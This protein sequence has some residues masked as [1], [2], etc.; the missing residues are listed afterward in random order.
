G[1]ATSISPLKL[2]VGSVV[3]PVATAS[4]HVKSV[5]LVGSYRECA[6]H[7][8]GTGWQMTLGPGNTT[9]KVAQFD[10]TCELRA[11]GLRRQLWN[12]VAAAVAGQPAPIE[13]SEQYQFHSIATDE[14]GT[15]RG[16]PLAP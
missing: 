10:S 11:T 16:G 6:G 1:A 12:G 2:D 9:V 3:H 13:I 7:V 15:V 5:S 4:L 8:S 14:K